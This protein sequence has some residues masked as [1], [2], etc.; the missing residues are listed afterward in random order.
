M[1]LMGR[2]WWLVFTA[3]NKLISTT[4]KMT[5]LKSSPKSFH[6]SMS[7]PKYIVITNLSSKSRDAAHSTLNSRV[8]SGCQPPQ[9]TSVTT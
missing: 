4:I 2:S 9:P 8:P 5:N 1:T 7:K 3:A 6:S